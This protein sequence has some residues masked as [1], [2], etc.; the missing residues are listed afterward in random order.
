MTDLFDITN[1]DDLPEKIKNS[2]SVQTGKRRNTVESKIMELFSIAKRP[3]TRNEIL[4]GLYRQF[5]HIIDRQKLTIVL[6]RAVKVNKTIKPLNGTLFVCN[7]MMSK[8]EFKN[9]NIVHRGR[10]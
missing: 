4:A 1:V 10:K 8:E 9:I 5:N 7:N 3:L 2:V 6:S